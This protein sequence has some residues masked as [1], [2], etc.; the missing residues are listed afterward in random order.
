MNKSIL[1]IDVVSWFSHAAYLYR[2]RGRHGMVATTTDDTSQLEQKQSE[3]AVSDQIYL[4]TIFKPSSYHYCWNHST[5][6]GLA[7][8]PGAFLTSLSLTLVVVGKALLIIL[9]REA[10]GACAVPLTDIHGFD[11]CWVVVVS[12]NSYLAWES[13]ASHGLS[14]M[15]PHSQ[16]CSTSGNP[17]C[18]SHRHLYPTLQ[19]LGAF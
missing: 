11:N 8:F 19:Y 13:E 10:P 1:S 15:L 7:S 16:S 3:E 12:L 5:Q 17:T 14:S 4:V 6:S 2:R 9:G 18:S